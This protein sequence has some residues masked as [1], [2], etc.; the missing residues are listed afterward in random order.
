M[1]FNILIIFQKDTLEQPS[2]VGVDPVDSQMDEQS[3]G[4]PRTHMSFNKG[5]PL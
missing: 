2:R 1:F 4:Q 3:A 5:D